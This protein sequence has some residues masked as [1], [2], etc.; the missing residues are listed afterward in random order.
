MGGQEWIKEYKTTAQYLGSHMTRLHRSSQT[1]G[2]NFY[3]NIIEGS[4]TMGS[5][6]S[7]LHTSAK[8]RKDGT[9]PTP[10]ID[11]G[12]SPEVYTERDLWDWLRHQCYLTHNLERFLKMNFWPPNFDSCYNYGKCEYTDLC[13]QGKNLEDVQTFNYIE[14]PH[15]DPKDRIEKEEG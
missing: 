4:P 12:R 7:V 14:I 13:Q 3:K 10:K 9:Y 5:I 2:Y 11:F 1:I 8:K 15:W 6:I